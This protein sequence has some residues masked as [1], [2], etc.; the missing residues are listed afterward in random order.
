[1]RG[2]SPSRSPAEGSLDIAETV[3]LA[4]SAGLTPVGQVVARRR[5]E[6]PRWLVGSGK[7]DEIRQIIE[8]QDANT[9][10]VNNDLSARQQRN[11]EEALGCR[12]M[13]RSELIIHIF[14]QRARTFE[15]QLQVELAQLTHAQTQLVGG[16]S[17]LE[18]QRGGHRLAWWCRRDAA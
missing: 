15:G 6:H 18:R 17:H 13:S 10:V 14:A 3:E 12:V 7:V 16:W 11:L 4:A 2:A 5:R 8:A 9:L 1:M